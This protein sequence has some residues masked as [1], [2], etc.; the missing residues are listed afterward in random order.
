VYSSPFDLWIYWVLTSN[1]L[2]VGF[3]A[4]SVRQATSKILLSGASTMQSAGLL[5]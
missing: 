3:L 5:V 1:I 4:A 2:L